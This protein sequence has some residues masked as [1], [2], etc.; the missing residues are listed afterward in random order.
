[1]TELE[2][3]AIE[4]K[5]N[6]NTGMNLTS[7]C[8]KN[9]QIHLSTYGFV[10]RVEKIIK[11]EIKSRSPRTDMD[12]LSAMQTTAIEEA[13][14]EQ[15]TYVLVVGDYSLIVGYDNANNSLTDLKELRKR[16]W[17]PLTIKTLTNAGLFNGSLDPKGRYPYFDEGGYYYR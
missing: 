5:F 11:E 8:S 2:V 16:Q 14:L 1:M 13:V 4:E 10:N 3:N 17:S 6:K 7:E 9:E 15:I 12:D